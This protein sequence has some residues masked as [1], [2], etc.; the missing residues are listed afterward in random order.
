M[1]ME[2]NMNYEKRFLLI[3]LLSVP[4]LL[5]VACGGRSSSV[6][7]SEARDSPSAS[8]ESGTYEIKVTR[9]GAVLSSFKSGAGTID[10]PLREGRLSIILNNPE[11]HYLRIGVPSSKAGVYEMGTPD[12][13]AFIQFIDE[14]DPQ[15]PL[16]FSCRKGEVEITECSERCSGSFNGSATMPDGDEFAASGSFSN[17]PLQKQ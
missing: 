10:A 12:K 11:K 5:F 17:V 13:A 6:P 3:S 15:K 4:L 16:S 9:N 7:A 1:Q 2:I 8:A 14:S